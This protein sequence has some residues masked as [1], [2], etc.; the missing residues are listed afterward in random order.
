M[1]VN[2]SVNLTGSMLR[3][4]AEAATYNLSTAYLIVDND[5]TTR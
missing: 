1:I 5:V 4:L 3:V 2:G